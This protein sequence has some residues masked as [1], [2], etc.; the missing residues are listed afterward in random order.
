VIDVPPS[1]WRSHKEM[2]I[3]QQPQD[4]IQLHQTVGHLANLWEDWAAHKVAQW[5][6]MMIWMQERLQKWDTLH[7]KDKLWGA[8]ITNII[9]KIM[10][11][12]GQG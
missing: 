3:R 7:E 8:D 4:L 11:G 9:A 6:G 1:D 2:T 10:N 12:V 5:R